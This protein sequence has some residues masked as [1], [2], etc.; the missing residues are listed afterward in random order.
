MVSLKSFIKEIEG[1]NV[2]KE[3]LK[4]LSPS[5]KSSYRS[6][7]ADFCIVNNI[8]PDEML[9]IIYQEEEER[10]PAWERS[11]NKWFTKYDEHCKEK[12]RTKGTRD[13]RRTIVNGFIGFHGLTQY[14]S[15][16]GRRK[17]NEFKE[18]NKRDALTK[19]DIKNMLEACKTWKMK[20]IIL[21]QSSSGLSGVDLINLKVKDF[22][23]G[24]K[25]VYD[26]KSRKTKKICRLH[27]TREKTKKEFITFLS[28][29]AV[30]AVEKYLE[31]GR[32]EPKPDEPLISNKK[33]QGKQIHQVTL[34]QAYRNINEYLG[35]T[36]E[37]RGRFRKATS[38][39]MRK[40]FNT[41][42]VYAGMPEEIREHFM[43]HTLDDKVR[44]AYFLEN[45]EE[46]QKVYLNYMDKITIR[47]VKPPITLSEY[48]EM[49][50][51]QED[52]RQENAKLK[53]ELEEIKATIENYEITIENPNEELLKENSELNEALSGLM[54]N[55]QIQEDK[56]EI[57]TNMM[58]KMN[59]ELQELKTE[60]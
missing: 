32:K 33:Y 38:H 24:L 2:V 16:G 30:E 49:K 12:N 6:A 4:D 51:D 8:K 40:F 10:L 26:K 15:K 42:L 1:L 3:W 47:T 34:H 37:E 28:E 53:T 45:E 9:E 52:L 13:N 29:E 17:T 25:E 60:A 20:A 23:E 56:I 46:L 22:Q 19:D 39:M 7:L 48:T 59:Q 11:I 58:K 57:L 43:G 14:S 50:T 44:D 55:N 27:L 18:A 41:Q 21:I 54:S 31:L 35:W 5:S 36:N